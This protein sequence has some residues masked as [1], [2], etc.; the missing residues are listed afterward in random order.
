M[1]LYFRQ[2]KPPDLTIR[3]LKK[4][5][6]EEEERV[7]TCSLQKAATLASFKQSILFGTDL[8]IFACCISII[9]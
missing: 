7:L 4:S 3:G 2:K 8:N 6:P 5:K 1:L 9:K